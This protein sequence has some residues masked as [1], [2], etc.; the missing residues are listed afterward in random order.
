L[1]VI[2]LGAVFA[3]LVLWNHMSGIAG[4]GRE[5]RASRERE[6]AIFWTTQ[7]IWSFLA[8]ALVLIGALE[9]AKAN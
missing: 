1:I 6:P 9:M 4:F 7:A 8:V 5:K 3:A 2:L